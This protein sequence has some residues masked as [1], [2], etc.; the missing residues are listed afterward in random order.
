MEKKEINLSNKEIKEKDGEKVNNTSI[1]EKNGDNLYFDSKSEI[2]NK[3]KNDSQSNISKSLSVINKNNNN[4]SNSEDD[5][6][7]MSI[8]RTISES[9][10]QHHYPTKRI[11]V[12]I[13]QLSKR[14]TKEENENEYNNRIMVKELRSKYFPLRRGNNTFRN[15]YH[16]LNKEKNT[17]INNENYPNN[18]KFKNMNVN[19]SK[20][21]NPNIFTNN[22]YDDKKP[23]KPNLF[24][25]DINEFRNSTQK[26]KELYNSY[27]GNN[28]YT[29]KSNNHF[30]QNSLRVSDSN[31]FS[32]QS[33]TKP[34]TL[35]DLECFPN[36][37][38]KIKA[39]LF[40]YNELL[41]NL[42]L[43]EQ[44]Y[45]TLKSKYNELNQNE[46]N[47]GNISI[48]EEDSKYKKYINE[49]NK[50]LS[51][52]LENYEKIFPQ[53][54]YYINDL[55]NELSLKK[56]NFVELKNYMN[57][58]FNNSNQDNPITSSIDILNEN[59]R[60]ILNRNKK[61]DSS[62]KKKTLNRIKSFS[63][64]KEYEE[65][66]KK[67]ITGRQGNKVKTK[68]FYDKL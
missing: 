61:K 32:E 62:N 50:N 34:L 37:N 17:I 39:L 38:E 68:K 10:N 60:T 8:I 20:S 16:N 27:N 23:T 53:M 1:I 13:N 46:R 54:I 31:N 58:N 51:S 41:K 52:K 15:N 6:K 65:L 67:I 43:F 22:R 19:I 63:N 64:N 29:S 18:F 47:S 5:K 36:D 28:Y 11:I 44:R 21:T 26:S 7:N 14:V 66:T 9:K 57:T 48:K 30:G 2:E 3:D 4:I 49:E 55:S 59:K 35:N 33:N 12:E 45:L 24:L 25:N 56:I 42:N 40:K